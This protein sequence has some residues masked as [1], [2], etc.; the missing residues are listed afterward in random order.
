MHK[1]IKRF[2]KGCLKCNKNKYSQPVRQGKMEVFEALRPFEIL[3]IDIVGPFKVSNRGNKFILVMIDHFTRWVELKAM[4]EITAEAVCQ[5]LFEE[6]ICRHGCPTKILSDQGKQFISEV[7]ADMCRRLGIKKIQT[8]PYHP[9]TNAHAERFNRYLNT[10]MRMY[11]DSTLKNWDEF[12]PAIAFAYRSGFSEAIGTTPF[13]L[14]HG[15]DPVLPED[16]EYGLKKDDMVNNAVWGLKIAMKHARK[17]QSESIRR[18]K[19]YYDQSKTDIKFYPGDKVMLYYPNQLINKLKPKCKGPF[20]VI[21]RIS[22]INYKIQDLRGQK[23][24]VV[25]VSRMRAYETN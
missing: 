16:V 5:V 20:R 11:V 9:Q 22:N 3:G 19:A 4:S 6:I 2:V 17:T 13:F 12:L 25:H 10:A 18:N 21:E 14:V 15:R 7:L 24:Q 8:S 1:D 23:N